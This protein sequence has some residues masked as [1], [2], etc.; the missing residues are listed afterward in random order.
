MTKSVFVIG[1]FV[2]LFERFYSAVLF[3]NDYIVKCCVELCADFT[4]I[5]FVQLFLLFLLSL[6]KSLFLFL[7]CKLVNS[8]KHLFIHKSILP[9]VILVLRAICSKAMISHN[10]PKCKF[11]ISRLK[12]KIF[13]AIIQL[14][15]LYGK[16]FRR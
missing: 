5:N 14:K 15:P 3:F 1:L 7:F 8:V 4:E 10:Q 11:S 2:C 6:G 16:F 9:T 13:C 12:T